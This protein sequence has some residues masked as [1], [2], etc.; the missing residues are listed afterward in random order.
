MSAYSTD[1]EPPRNL[2]L[3][4]RRLKHAKSANHILLTPSLC[5]ARRDHP[6]T[7]PPSPQQPPM[8]DIMLYTPDVTSS[9][10]GML[11]YSDSPSIWD[12]MLKNVASTKC[13]SRQAANYSP[14]YALAPCNQETVSFPVWRLGKFRGGGSPEQAELGM[15]SAICLQD[16][17]Q[18]E[19]PFYPNLPTIFGTL[20]RQLWREGEHIIWE[21][22]THLY[23]YTLIPAP[24]S[25]FV[26][27]VA[28][29]DRLIIET[30]DVPAFTS[31]AGQRRSVV[32]AG[33][34]ENTEGGN[35][36]E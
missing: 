25:P 28:I 6:H 11:T 4:L 17:S 22:D 23:S 16:V 18:R 34:S 20:V 26:M 8:I 13:L 14:Y 10:S 15:G 3:P 5:S 35:G 7:P 29:P 24:T 21:L 30:D 32:W 9:V 19:H 36:D 31:Y 33:I 1:Y 12:I 27:R 2:P